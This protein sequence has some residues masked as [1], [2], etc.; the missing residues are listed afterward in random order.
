MDAFYPMYEELCRPQGMLLSEWS[1]HGGNDAEAV[2]LLRAH[3]A[4]SERFAKNFFG[5]Q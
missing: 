5:L 1:L 3:D 2:D 4:R